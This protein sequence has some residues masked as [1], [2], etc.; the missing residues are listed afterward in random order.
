[1]QQLICNKFASS[2]TEIICQDTILVYCLLLTE[3]ETLL[4]HFHTLK[5]L[6]LEVEK[7]ELQMAG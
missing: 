1:V 2:N 6:G 3:A 4:P 5:A 7:A